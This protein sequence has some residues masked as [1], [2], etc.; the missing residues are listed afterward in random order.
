MVPCEVIEDIRKSL[1]CEPAHWA[2]IHY[3]TTLQRLYSGH[4]HRAISKERKIAEYFRHV[5]E[6]PARTSAIVIMDYEMKLEQIRYRE[7]SVEFY[8]KRGMIWLGAVV[9]LHRQVNE[10][11]LGDYLG[12]L[13]LDHISTNDNGHD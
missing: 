10:D 7:S 6:I 4:L 12:T 2:V 13:V 8:G 1:F 9:L 11:A 3:P 5:K